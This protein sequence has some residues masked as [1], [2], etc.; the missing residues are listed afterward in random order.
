VRSE[1]G[2]AVA[3]FGLSLTDA[4]LGALVTH[5]QMLLDANQLLN[6]TRI[7]DEGQLAL[8]HVADSLSLL[9]FLDEAPAGSFADLGSGGGYP[10][11]PLV[12]VSGRPG[13][14]VESTQK[15]AAF[16]TEVVETLGLDIDV[17]P[18]RAEELAATRPNAFA[19]VTAR[20]VSALPSLVELAAP[21]L[22]QNGLLLAMKGEPSREELAA[23]EQVARIAGMEALGPTRIVVAGLKAQRSV[24]RYRRVG[25][26]SVRLPRR[27]GLAQR[28][29]LA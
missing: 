6:L 1:I 5:A 16:L 8:A 15:K 28:H 19:A 10:G 29:P 11:I 4:Q 9:P 2:A 7:T 27:P 25:R 23:G 18:V 3:V 22:E 26:P 17:Q 14:L 24:V 20:A 21:L 13:V 12:I